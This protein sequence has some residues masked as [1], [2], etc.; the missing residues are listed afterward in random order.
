MTRFYH[1]VHEISYC[2]ELVPNLRNE[3]N[4]M[5]GLHLHPSEFFPGRDMITLQFLRV[6]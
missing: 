4:K 3:F 1:T 2:G 6:L 5:N